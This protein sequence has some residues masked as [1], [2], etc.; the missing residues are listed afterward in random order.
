MNKHTLFIVALLILF[1]INSQSQTNIWDENPSDSQFELDSL[2]T[3]LPTISKAKKPAMLNR[4]A[5][6]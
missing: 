1:G 6:I 4:I 5:E 2:L 3:V